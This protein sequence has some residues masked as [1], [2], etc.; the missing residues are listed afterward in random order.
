MAIKHFEGDPSGDA[1]RMAHGVTSC[2]GYP[3]R[4][5]ALKMVRCQLARPQE[6]LKSHRV[7]PATTVSLVLGAAFFVGYLRRP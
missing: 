7:N 6:R 3:I 1:G 4:P 5:L 2:L